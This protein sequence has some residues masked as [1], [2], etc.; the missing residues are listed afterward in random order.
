LGTG[1]TEYDECLAALQ[2][3]QTELTRA[4]LELKGPRADLAAK[5]NDYVIDTLDYVASGG[6]RKSI[7]AQDPI[8]LL[9]S[10]KNVKIYV[11]EVRKDSIDRSIVIELQVGIGGNATTRFLTLP[12]HNRTVLAVQEFLP[13]V[14][15]GWELTFVKEGRKISDDTILDD[16]DKVIALLVRRDFAVPDRP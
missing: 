13:N 8:N 4:I 6:T 1:H 15:I 16:G 5:L 2:E 9:K 7:P 11:P 3:A 10:L 12:R 14:K